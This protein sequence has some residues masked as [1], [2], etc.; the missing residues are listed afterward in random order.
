MKHRNRFPLRKETGRTPQGGHG[1]GSPCGVRQRCWQRQPRAPRRGRQSRSVRRARD[2]APRL[3]RWSA[4]TS[5]RGGDLVKFFGPFQRRILGKTL[6]ESVGA[7]Q[8]VAPEAG[9]AG[10]QVRPRQRPPAATVASVARDRAM[11]ANWTQKHRAT[12]A[13]VTRFDARKKKP[14]G[15]N[16]TADAPAFARRSCPIYPH[17][18]AIQSRIW[19]WRNRTCAP[20]VRL[21]PRLPGQK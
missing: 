3:G 15:D 17:C 9:G 21:H 19:H 1:W 20:S 7:F 6:G 16:E 11:V 13:S 5:I 14:S 18:V 12:L 10:G 8:G 4:Q 2:F